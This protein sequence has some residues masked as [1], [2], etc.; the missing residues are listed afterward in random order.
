MGPESRE[1]N[2]QL[3]GTVQLPDGRQ[4]PVTVMVDWAELEQ[5]GISAPDP[6]LLRAVEV[7]GKAQKTLSW[8]NT[9]NADFHGKTPRLAAQTDEG[10]AQVLGVLFD[11]ER[12]FPA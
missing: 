6:L 9:A 12:G 10:K 3:D 11:L 4:L 5:A 8:L 7:F 2:T 1:R